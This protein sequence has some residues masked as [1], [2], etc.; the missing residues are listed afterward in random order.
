[1]LINARL[2]FQCCV[3]I[4]SA[5]VGTIAR[6]RVGGAVRSGCGISFNS[7]VRLKLAKVHRVEDW[8]L[9]SEAPK[10]ASCENHQ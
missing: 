8:S 4:S 5:I 2:D 9:M 1:M 7:G 3:I 10:I 6:C